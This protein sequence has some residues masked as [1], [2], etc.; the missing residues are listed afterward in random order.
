M[1]STDSAADSETAELLF[2]LGRAQA[3][4]QRGEAF[5]SLGRAFDYY[6]EVGDVGRIVAIAE[7][8][9]YGTG[10][11]RGTGVVQLIVRA[12]EQVPP[13]S[14]E[15]GRLLCQH[16]QV[17]GLRDGDYQEA[18]DA[19]EQALVIARREGDA[20]LQMQTLGAAT[21]V[22]SNHMRYDVC[23]EHS[24]HAI[25][26]ASQVDDPRSE[27]TARYFAVTC[28]INNGDLEGAREHAFPM[29][30][31]AERL[32][33][34]FWLAGAL[35]KNEIVYRLA[36]EWRIGR[37]LTDRGLLVASVPVLLLT[38]RVMLEFEVGDVSQGEAFLERLLEDPHRTELDQG[39]KAM[40]VA[41]VS[42]ING[43]VEHLDA[44]KSI[45]QAVLESAPATPS[46]TE[47]ARIALALT[48]VQQKDITLAANQY[49]A[50]KSRQATMLFWA[51]TADRLLGLLLS[52]MGE[53]DQ[54]LVHFDNALAFC[55]RAGY[56]PEYAWTCYDYAGTLMSRGRPG[57]RAKAMSLLD[58][59]LEVSSDLG[60]RPLTEKAAAL[61]ESAPSPQGRAPQF[62]D[63]LT[64]REVQVLRLVATGKTDREIAD[65]LI[66]GVR[67]VT[68]H[69]S[70]I[71]G[72]TRSANRTE[73]A[74]YAARNGLT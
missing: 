74:A 71:L 24:L 33:D 29:L 28:F 22:A 64:Q 21:T 12:L 17:V 23:L 9:D 66:I 6:V 39:C 60:M 45:A 55:R 70:N 42:R 58:E 43:V 53:I 69:V 37:D 3:V 27:V 44:A 35:W 2:G 73:A 48:A 67:T 19:F 4:L 61:R 47:R 10:L 13:H 62:P 31:A 1:T 72:K 41:L 68:T 26:L 14:H 54:A 20:L 18:Q 50:L 52:T 40:A 32:R 57:S 59:A 56:R 7:Y 8:P 30:T 5:T 63:G 34:R 65:E 36:G 51:V 11:W 46:A 25:E 15:A 16:G 49:A 38:D